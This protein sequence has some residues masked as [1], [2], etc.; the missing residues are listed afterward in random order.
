MK[1]RIKKIKEEL[2]SPWSGGRID[3]EG[4]LRIIKKQYSKKYDVYHN[5]YIKGGDCEIM[6][7]TNDEEFELIL[8]KHQKYLEY[9]KELEINGYKHMGKGTYFGTDKKGNRIEATLYWGKSPHIS[10]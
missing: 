2:E 6:T 9:K 4:E 1:N 10:K 7:I 3:L 8:E 5:S